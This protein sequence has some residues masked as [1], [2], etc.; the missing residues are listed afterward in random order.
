MKHEANHLTQNVKQYSRRTFIQRAI[1][2]GL[3]VAAAE[4]LWA[5]AARAQQARGGHMRLAITGGST[6]DSLDP[7]TFTDTFMLMVGYSVRGNLTEVAPDGSVVP[8][9]AESFEPADKGAKWV[10]KLR[11]G[12]EFSNGKKLTAEDV[13]KSINLHRGEN[14]ASGG[15]PL[16]VSI[17]DIKADGDSAVVFTLTEGNADFPFVVADYHL[18]IMPFNGDSYDE[19]TGC[20]PFLLKDYQPGVRATLERNKNS[21]KQ[22]FIDSAQIIG[23]PDATSRQSAL[24]AREVDLVNRPDLTT[25]GRLS[26]APGLVVVDVAGRMHFTMPANAQI[27]PYNNRDFCLAMKYAIDREALVKKILHGHG[28]V[29]NDS[30]ITPSYKYF[31]AELKPRPYDP[32][33]ARFHLKKSG[34][35]GV[36]LDLSASDTAFDGAVDAALLY[37][38]SAAKAGLSVNVIKEPADGYWD[39]VWLK[40]SFCMVYWGGRPTEDI[41]LTQAY[42]SKAPWNET[43][44]DSKKFDDL[45]VAARSELDDAKRRSMYSELQHLIADECSTIIPAFANHVHAATDKVVAPEELSGTW[46]LDGGRCLERWSMKA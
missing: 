42:Y 9:L 2:T 26:K 45:L 23:V 33:K 44:W 22:V 6:T 25:V 21:Y 17:A 24:L 13:V 35:E 7:Q 10:F 36:K 18:N 31:D 20:G 40:K 1:A 8:E 43:H 11:S 27:A 30:P 12:V 37:A 15:K 46:E 16:L 28:T 5:G 32:E 39:T 34:I 38:D 14:S 41:Q 3:T 19:T 29:G 4:A